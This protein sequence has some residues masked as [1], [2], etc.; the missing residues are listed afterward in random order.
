[1]NLRLEYLKEK[2]KKD[3]RDYRDYRKTKQYVNELYMDIYIWILW[4]RKTIY[5]QSYKSDDIK[6]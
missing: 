4:I 1:M 5:K 6:S 3:Y 2:T